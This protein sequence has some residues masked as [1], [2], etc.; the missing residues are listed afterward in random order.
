[1]Q[2]EESHSSIMGDE[3]ISSTENPSSLS[4]ETGGD[5]RPSLAD[6]IPILDVPALGAG[7][8]TNVIIEP[9]PIV[10]G[11][12]LP[13]IV[14]IQQGTIRV[15]DEVA[16]AILKKDD[17]LQVREIQLKEDVV[18][19]EVDI[20]VSIMIAQDTKIFSPAKDK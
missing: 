2:Q 17:E 16:S 18:V 7:T 15:A 4:G 3:L 12:K 6:I 9:L 1:M 10:T 14:W 8:V 11:G 5:T 20:G 13:E 19:S